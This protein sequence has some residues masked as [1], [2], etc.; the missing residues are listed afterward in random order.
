MTKIT[1]CA[2]NA[3]NFVDGAKYMEANVAAR[4]KGERKGKLHSKYRF[5]TLAR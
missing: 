2:T 3:G 5:R 1:N 4:L